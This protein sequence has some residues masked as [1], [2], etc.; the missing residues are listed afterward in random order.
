MG[1]QYAKKKIYTILIVM[2]IMMV[3]LFSTSCAIETRL[4]I[5]KA[6]RKTEKLDSIK[7][8]IQ[9][10]VHVSVDANEQTGYANVKNSTTII[11]NDVNS[12]SPKV[13]YSTESKNSS[14][15][16]PPVS[17]S[18]YIE[19]GYWYN[20]SNPGYVP[21]Q[22]KK[23]DYKEYIGDA[24]ILPSNKILNNA[25]I[26]KDDKNDITTI[27]YSIANDDAERFC[28]YIL[29]QISAEL[30][31]YE[32]ITIENVNVKQIIKAGYI[33]E[34]EITLNL[35]MRDND[36]S[37]FASVKS[38]VKIVNPGRHFEITLPKNYPSSK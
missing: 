10:D 2:L 3:C 18:F 38:T 22:G 17:N 12:A 32:D 28:H 33:S 26:T 34:F 29:E 27:K 21:T 19:D 11:V 37:V 16:L 13:Y 6:I 20:Y 5:N 1:K 25:E 7:S 14:T 36:N 9:T 8:T 35:K 24:F 30:D 31:D 4:M 15:G 23:F